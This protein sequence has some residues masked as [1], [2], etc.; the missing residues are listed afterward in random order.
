MSGSCQVAVNG[1][2]VWAYVVELDD[3]ARLRLDLTDWERTGLC[4][5]RRVPL[6]LPGKD[7]VWLFITHAT[8]VPP[9]VWVVMSK[10]V[11]AAG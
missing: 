4:I 5:G 9:F 6:R 3:G 7:D 11:R 8:E 10:R 1:S 2:E